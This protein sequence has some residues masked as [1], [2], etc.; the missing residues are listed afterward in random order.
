MA[1][2]SASSVFDFIA[3]WGV[4]RRENYKNIQYHTKASAFKGTV[5]PLLR[6]LVVHPALVLAVE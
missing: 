3:F 5:L 1:D 6:P 2:G 4:T